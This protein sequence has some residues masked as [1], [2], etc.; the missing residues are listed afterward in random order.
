MG[1]IIAVVSGKGGTGKTSFTASVALSLAAMGYRTLALDCDITLRNL[2][3]ALGLSDSTTMDFSDV[4]DGRCQLNEAVAQHRKYTQLDLLAAPLSGH[5]EG[6]DIDK[7]KRL[8]GEIREK[9]DYCLVDAPAGLGQGFLLATAIADRVV[10][11]TTADP[12]SLR[13]AQRTVSSLRQFPTGKLHLV[14]NRVQKKMLKVLHTTIDDAMDTAGAPLLGVVPEDNEVPLAVGRGIPL[15][16]CNY[17]AQQAYDNI[18]KR[19]TGK[20]VPLM[21]V[22]PLMKA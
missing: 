9:Y 21:K 4:L 16:D 22:Y 15:R 3:M 5:N 19:L 13:D 1:T 17:F 20:K 7:M 6:F 2:D 14:V 18:A 11:I 12:T 10:V 8:G